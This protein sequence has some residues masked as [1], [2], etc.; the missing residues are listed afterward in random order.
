MIKNLIFD[1]GNVLVEWK[2]ESLMTWMGIEDPLDRKILTEKMFSSLE[3]PLLD[4]GDINEEEAEK[5]F[6]SRIPERLW[7]YI[8]HSL[9][10]KDMIHPIPHMADFIK[11]KK[12]EGYGIYLLSNAPASMR[13]F[14][15]RIPSSEYFDGIVFSGEVKLVKPMK[16][17]YH[18][19]LDRYSLKEEECLFIDDLPIN[20]ASACREGL[21]AYVFRG[22]TE[23]LEKYLEA[24]N[25]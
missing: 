10:W 5:I 6:S 9:Y 8:H 20:C 13:E 22:D 24:L 19:L 12:A 18:L 3:W 14:F 1:M 7:K 25:S 15:H 11:R 4:W 17:I 21:S 16:E 2:G 23:E